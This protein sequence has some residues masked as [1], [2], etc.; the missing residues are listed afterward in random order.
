MINT[1]VSA[2]I[3]ELELSLKVLKVSCN[4]P[5]ETYMQLY[6]ISCDLFI[7]YQTQCTAWIYVFNKRST[8]KLPASFSY[9]D[10]NFGK[11]HKNLPAENVY[12]AL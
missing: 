8:V 12:M 2:Q 3:L 7:Y 11:F 10:W 1:L 9:F 5:A 4:L 6:S